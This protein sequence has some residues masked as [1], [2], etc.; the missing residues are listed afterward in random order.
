MQKGDA[1]RKVIKLVS[2]LLICSC[3]PLAI[4]GCSLSFGC[5]IRNH[6]A[7]QL[8]VKADWSA[9]DP[10]YTNPSGK[11]HGGP[12]T[13]VLSNLPKGDLGFLPLWPS[14]PVTSLRIEVS[15]ATNLRGS[16]PRKNLPMSL[17]GE[18]ASGDSPVL[19]IFPDHMQF[20]EAT[21]LEKIEANPQ[22]YLL[23][24]C[25]CLSPFPIAMVILFFYKRK[26]TVSTVQSANSRSRLLA[27]DRHPPCSSR[28]P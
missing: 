10:F 17:Q 9:P 11:Q 25:C 2:G 24:G 8:T 22:W 13:R 14:G 19:D 12:A 4:S 26:R 15:G 3:L 1:C 21:P 27:D 23:Q 6:S 16:W 7:G 28:S 5:Y 18:F 20:R